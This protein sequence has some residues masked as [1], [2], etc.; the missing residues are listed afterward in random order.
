MSQQ[1]VFAEEWRRCLR[2][3]YM[4]V[5]RSKDMLTAQSLT[6]VMHRVGFTDDD[7]RELRIR[8]TMRADDMPDDF[9]PAEVSAAAE[10]FRPHP[11][12]CTCPD[13]MTVDESRHDADG[14]PLAVMP[15]PEEP[16]GRVF[17]AAG[18]DDDETLDGEKMPEDK[19]G[20]TDDPDA[21]QLSLF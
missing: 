21:Q 6:D 18:M 20:E 7:L 17:A 14:Q 8:A 2:E 12:E 3:Q 1:S 5:I 11:A 15:E 16:A 13:C 19:T 10:T 9:V 4:Y